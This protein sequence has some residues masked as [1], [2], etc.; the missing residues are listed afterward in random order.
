MILRN[1]RP[2]CLLGILAA[3]SSRDS[4][5]LL[6]FKVTTL[7]AQQSSASAIQGAPFPATHQRSQFAFHGSDNGNPAHAF[8]AATCIAGST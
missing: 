6:V 3:D 1:H 5:H 8:T 4:D 7:K 2:G